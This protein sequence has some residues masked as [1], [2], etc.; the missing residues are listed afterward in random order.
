MTESARILHVH[1]KPGSR[2]G[3]LV[4]ADPA[5]EDAFTVFLAQRAIEGAAN[6]ALVRLLA[7]H[8]GVPRSA[9]SILRGHHSRIKQVRVER[10]L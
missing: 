6:D 1:V 8:L 9:V 10:V 5:A 4:Q 3:P 2:K 7:K